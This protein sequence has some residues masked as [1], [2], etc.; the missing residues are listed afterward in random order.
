MAQEAL[1][2]SDIGCA[3]YHS[4]LGPIRISAS[5]RGI[6]SVKMLFGKH[7]SSSAAV[8]DLAAAD[9]GVADERFQAHLKACIAW[10]D[11]YFQRSEE[12]A[13]V[14]MPALDLGDKG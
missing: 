9:V 4:P 12:N 1:R 10:L 11:K 8:G 13:L 7:G 2:A 5:Q 6:V 3:I 14:A